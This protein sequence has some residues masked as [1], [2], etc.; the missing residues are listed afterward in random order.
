[1]AA[2][3]SLTASLYVTRRVSWAETRFAGWLRAGAPH[4]RMATLIA[5]LVVLVALALVLKH[6]ADV[7]KRLLFDL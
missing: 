6:A 3:L 1:V 2:A 4:R 5:A 7:P